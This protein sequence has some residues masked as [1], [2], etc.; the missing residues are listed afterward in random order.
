MQLLDRVVPFL[1]ASQEYTLACTHT[2]SRTHKRTLVHG[3]AAAPADAAADCRGKKVLAHWHVRMYSCA[4]A[5]VH[6]YTHTR[7]YVY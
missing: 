2:H 6:L 5:F 4:Y 3:Q 1:E 7:A